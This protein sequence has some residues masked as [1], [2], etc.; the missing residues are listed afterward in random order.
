MVRGHVFVA[1]PFAEMARRPLGH[2]ARI[3]ED[4]RCA[5]SGDQLS[6]AIID[7]LENLV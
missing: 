5:M 2:P 6:E 3:D 7:L 4:Q 1:D